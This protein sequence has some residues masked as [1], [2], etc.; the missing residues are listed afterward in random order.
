MQLNSRSDDNAHINEVII[1]ALIFLESNIV[2]NEM[3]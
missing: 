2:S 1:S 3:N